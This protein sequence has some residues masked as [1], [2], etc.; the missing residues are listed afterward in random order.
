MDL[1]VMERTPTDSD[2]NEVPAPPFPPKT[3]RK[4]GVSLKV[5]TALQSPM[6]RSLV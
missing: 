5:V 2:S 1:D 3:M 6:Q 4:S